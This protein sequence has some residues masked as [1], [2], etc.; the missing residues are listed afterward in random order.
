[1]A[2]E[3]ERMRHLDAN[4]MKKKPIFKNYIESN[5]NIVRSNM[6]KNKLQNLL[7]G[8]IREMSIVKNLKRRLGQ[9]Q[10][11]AGS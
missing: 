8:E 9:D 3:K 4:F 7:D 2:R 10:G 6:T 5:A 1:M 11:R